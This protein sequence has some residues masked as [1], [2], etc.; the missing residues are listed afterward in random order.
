MIQSQELPAPRCAWASQQ[1]TPGAVCV[2][3]GVGG[4]HKAGHVQRGMSTARQYVLSAGMTLPESW[5]APT[6]LTPSRP[7]TETNGITTRITLQADGNAIARVSNSS[8]LPSLEWGERVKISS[9]L[10]TE[11]EMRCDMRRPTGTREA[12]CMHHGDDMLWAAILPKDQFVQYLSFLFTRGGAE[13]SRRDSG[14][15]SEHASPCIPPSPIRVIAMEICYSNTEK[16]ELPSGGE[17]LKGP[18]CCGW[19]LLLSSASTP[20]KAISSPQWTPAAAIH[21]RGSW[22]MFG[23]AAFILEGTAPNRAAPILCFNC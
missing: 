2:A 21:I 7:S 12:T 11:K 22:A 1:G 10:P 13:T 17:D 5:L 23:L 18:Q 14:I 20:S 3:V 6:S 16:L 9:L 19:S 8:S 4:G 15:H